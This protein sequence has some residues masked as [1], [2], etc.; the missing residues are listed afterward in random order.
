MWQHRFGTEGESTGM[1]QMCASTCCVQICG[2]LGYEQIFV[3]LSTIDMLHQDT[4][5]CAVAQDQ[6]RSRRKPVHAMSRSAGV[7]DRSRCAT[8]QDGSRDEVVWDESRE[9]AVQNR[10]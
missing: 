10:S 7:L 8:V 3:S 6:S 2:W 5:G 1:L 9:A 4:S